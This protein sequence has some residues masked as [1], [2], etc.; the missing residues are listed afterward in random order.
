MYK[1]VL[2]DGGVSLVNHTFEGENFRRFSGFVAIRE[3][4][5]HRKFRDVVSF[6]AA[7]ASNLRKFSPRKSY[8]SPIHKRFLP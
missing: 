2:Q 5:L 7:K 6:G 8:F 1:A 4:F 3:S